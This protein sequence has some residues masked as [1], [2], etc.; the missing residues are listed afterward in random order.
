MPV[1]N[2]PAAAPL[3]VVL[4]VSVLPFLTD[5]FVESDDVVAFLV[6]RQAAEAMPLGSTLSVPLNTALTVVPAGGES[7]RNVKSAVRLP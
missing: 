7:R 5:E 1:G 2:V 6:D 4:T 3:T